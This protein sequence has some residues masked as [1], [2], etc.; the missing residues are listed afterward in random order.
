ME[1]AVRN[2]VKYSM[3]TRYGGFGYYLT[4]VPNRL[5]IVNDEYRNWLLQCDLQYGIQV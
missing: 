1:N 4:F 2:L 3:N 5:M